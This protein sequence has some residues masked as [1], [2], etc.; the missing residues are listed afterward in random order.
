ME[1]D[2]KYINYNEIN[3]ESFGQSEP[4]TNRLSSI[5]RDYPK[6]TQ[7]F[8]ELIQNA[9]DARAT[10]FK[11][12]FDSRNHKTE[13]L[14][15]PKMSALQGASI[16]T[17]NNAK[18][19]SKDFESIRNL[20]QSR[21]K[22]D[23][24]KIGTFGIG[25]NSVYHLTDFP[26]FVS[27]KFITIFD[28][29]RKCINRELLVHGDPGIRINFVENSNLYEKY[30]DQ[31]SPF[32]IFGCDIKNKKPFNGT[33]FR[34]PL[35][36]Q[37]ISKNSKISTSSYDN[38]VVFKLMEK[39]T[40]E[41][42]ENIL[43]LKHVTHV[44]AYIMTEDDIEPKKI[45]QLDITELTTEDQE[46]R[47]KINQI[48]ETDFIQ[49]LKDENLFYQ[50]C[51]N[52]EENFF[53]KKEKKIG[54][55]ILSCGL[56][57]GSAKKIAQ[58]GKE[59]KITGRFVPWG[60]IA[61]CISEKIKGRVFCFLPLASETGL[62]VHVNSFF[63]MSSNRRDLWKG[64]HS[65]DSDSAI[66]SKWNEAL[67]ED[68]LGPCYAELLSFIKK[69]NKIEE[70]YSLFPDFSSIGSDWRKLVQSCYQHL[71]SQNIQIFE[72]D[73]G[74][75]ISPKE[76]II[77]DNTLT[78]EIKD[79]S[80]KIFKLTNYSFLR[81]ISKHVQN[82]FELSHV[83]L[84]HLDSNVMRTALKSI[85]PKDLEISKQEAFDLL[86]FISMDKKYEDFVGVP[87]ILLC[88]GDKNVF[89]YY[90]TKNNVYLVNSIE[91][92]LLCDKI[93]HQIVDAFPNEKLRLLYDEIE[94]SKMVNLEH[95]NTEILNTIF[96]SIFPQ[97]WKNK[98]ISIE[99]SGFSN[100]FIIKMWNYLG[101]GTTEEEKVANWPLI[102]CSFNGKQTLNIL[103]KEN[104][105][106]LLYI[107]QS[108]S[109]D[110]LDAIYQFNFKFIDSTIISEKNS[111]N[112]K[113][114]K[115][116]IDPVI[117]R[118]KPGL[119]EKLSDQQKI[120]LISF[121]S[122][123][124]NSKNQLFS[125][126]QKS[127]I[128][129]L[130]LFRTYDGSFG[131]LKN[132]FLPPS[133]FEVKYLDGF[134]NI[135]K[136]NKK[137]TMFLEY[138]GVKKLNLNQFYVEILFPKIA[139][140]SLDVEKQNEVMISLITKDLPFLLS[141]D[142]KIKEYLKDLKFI[143]VKNG[144]F[145]SPSNVYDPRIENLSLLLQNETV[146]PVGK[147][148][149]SSVLH[150]LELLGMNTTLS[151]KNFKT[152]IEKS[153]RELSV[154]L[155][156]Y[157]DKNDNILTSNFIAWK[158]VIDSNQKIKW[159][160]IQSQFKNLESNLDFPLDFMSTI[161]S[162]R[163]NSD[164]HL[165]SSVYFISE[166]DIF[167]EPL[168]Q[169]LGWIPIGKNLE[170]FSSHIIS[171][172]KNVSITFLKNP[173]DLDIIN[174]IE[175]SKG[176]IYSTLETLVEKE[177]IT[178]SLKF[179]SL[180]VENRFV[181]PNRVAKYLNFNLKP[182]LFELPAYL[183]K[184]D[185]LMKF[186]SIKDQFEPSDLIK[187]LNL[188]PKD[189]IL[190]KEE[191]IQIS[192]SILQKIYKHEGLKNMKIK[193]P[194]KDGEF[195]NKKLLLYVDSKEKMDIIT[196]IGTSEFKFVHPTIAPEVCESLG[197]VS[198]SQQLGESNS[199]LLMMNEDVLGESFGQKISL[200]TRIGNILQD[201]PYSDNT[202][203]IELLQ[204]AEDAGA[205]Q[206]SV[207]Y[208]KRT[209]G[210][211]RLFNKELSDFQGPSLLIYNNSV[212]SDKDI[213]SIQQ[214]GN[215]GKM[216]NLEK[217]GRF[218]IGF[219]SV[220]HLTDLPSFVSDSNLVIMDP[221]H[222]FVN[223]SSVVNPGRKYKFNSKGMGELFSDQLKPYQFFGFSSDDAFNGTIFRLPLRNLSQSEK[224]EL[225]EEHWSETQ[226]MKLINN[227]VD[228][229]K[230]CMIF[231][232]NVKKLSIHIQTDDEM[233]D[234]LKVNVSKSLE[235]TSIENIILKNM[236][237]LNTT[238]VLSKIKKKNKKRE[239]VISGNI[240]EI[241][242]CGKLY[243]EVVN[244][245]KETKKEEWIISSY[246]GANLNT[247]KLISS[248][249]D[250]KMRF[251]P[252]A[253]VAYCIDEKIR[254]RV[255]SSLPLPIYSGL[256]VH[257]NSFFEMG[258]NRREI[259][260]SKT[261]DDDIRDT[262]NKT[263]IMSNVNPA[264]LALLETLCSRKIDDD[265]KCFQSLIDLFPISKNFGKSIFSVILTPF[266]EQI[267]KFKIFHRSNVKGFHILKDFSFY[268]SSLFKSFDKKM[269]LDLLESK[270]DM[271]ELP[272]D[273]IEEFKSNGLQNYLLDESS[274]KKIYKSIYLNEKNI[275]EENV[276]TLWDLYKNES[277]SELTEFPILTMNKEIKKMNEVVTTITTLKVSKKKTKEVKKKTVIQNTFY[278]IKDYDVIPLI[279][280][281]MKQFIIDEK[282]AE[283]FKNKNEGT[284]NEIGIFY[285]NAK[286]L[287]GL[288]CKTPMNFL[289]LNSYVSVN[290]VS[291]KWIE[292]LW[293]YFGKHNEIKDDFLDWSLIPTTNG[294]KKMEKGKSI[295]HSYLPQNLRSQYVDV[296]KILKRIEIPFLLERFQNIQY[297]RHCVSQISNNYVLNH[298]NRSTCEKLTNDEKSSLI[299][300]FNPVGLLDGEI[301]KLKKLPLFETITGKFEQINHNSCLISH[302]NI[303]PMKLNL[304]ILK[305]KI[306]LYSL[307]KKLNIKI[308]ASDLEIYDQ[309]YLPKFEQLSNSEKIIQLEYIFKKKSL[310]MSLID[311]L[312]ILKFLGPNMNK[313]PK[314]CFNPFE[315]LFIEF[316]SN[317]DFPQS[318][319]N[320][321]E[322][323]EYLIHCG[324][325]KEIDEKFI[326]DCCFNLQK[327][328]SKEEMIRKS[329]ILIE[330]IMK[331]ENRFSGSF[332]EEIKQI[333][334]IP[335]IELDK[336]QYPNAKESN[337]ILE[338]VDSFIH[339]K[340]KNL[341]WTT[342]N[343]YD[344]KKYEKFFNLLSTKSSTS[345]YKPKFI[346]V[347][348][349]LHN[350]TQEKE[351]EIPELQKIIIEIYKYLNSNI[352]HS[353]GLNRFTDPKFIY[354]NGIFHFG[355]T[356]FWKM[357]QNYPPY[358]YA[359]PEEYLEFKS[360]FNFFQ[361]VDS[362]S[363]KFCKSVLKIL[364]KKNEEKKKLSPSK[365]ELGFKLIKIILVDLN[366][367]MNGSFL[368][369]LK[370]NLVPI[371][372]V[373][374]NDAPY[375]NEKIHL[376]EFNILHSKLNEYSENLNLKRLS[377]LVEERL[378]F[379]NQKLFSNDFTDQINKK[380]KS[381]EFILGL[382]R[383]I[384]NEFRNEEK[385]I[386]KILDKIKELADLKMCLVEFLNSSF[387]DIRTEKEIKKKNEEIK[388]SSYCF[389][390]SNLKNFYLLKELP[391][392][393]DPFILISQEINKFLMYPL[394]DSIMISILFKCENDQINIVL[395]TF[396]ISDFIG[397]DKTIHR[398]LGTLILKKD[399]KFFKKLND[400]NVKI[401]ELIVYEQN[402]KKLYYGRIVEKLSNEQ[403]KVKMST[404]TE[405]ILHSDLIFQFVDDCDEEEKVFLNDEKKSSVLEKLQ[406]NL[407]C[408]ITREI[409]VN[410]VIAS[411]GFT[412]E[413]E[414]IE[415]WM[416]R[417]LN[418]PMTRE[419]M[420][421]VLIQN[422]QLKM[423][424]SEII[425][426]EK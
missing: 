85:D 47:K 130:K 261:D 217:I 280:D 5:L 48:L 102:P 256:N 423:I 120:S 192:V 141:N 59:S 294:M 275:K 187:V 84:K 273:I 107:N 26:C 81:N 343:F 371:R 332:F 128:L 68:I 247:W 384:K 255:Y 383:I 311:Q 397:D 290:S 399:E 349:H 136:Y 104:E 291:Q 124:F 418:S 388:N 174:F 46:K 14:L 302:S 403:F 327:I 43:F 69:N 237:K 225:S 289:K 272:Q 122:E 61:C 116:S 103:G 345:F 212:F 279:I 408:P 188:I 150:N 73:A 30:S 168:K 406:S 230:N 364:Y 25:F 347:L 240:D 181:E 305:E 323:V 160:P 309:L 370:L 55:W 20:A 189:S 3:F 377:L 276:F 100:E 308:Y 194:T 96:H 74:K 382:T 326:L 351:T 244:E 338:R 155:L 111:G 300:F 274:V 391:S 208:D 286:S 58:Q 348:N 342:M 149:D 320:T 344:S 359:C 88:N 2:T 117:K 206:F 63:E 395:D 421:S 368:F 51:L 172:L 209:H 254:G 113:I 114:S 224:S 167:S 17:F 179:S 163:P 95:F 133:N 144:K 101:L 135:L 29:H 215:Q 211:K 214:L 146:F 424:I 60:N 288:L 407:V 125:D 339:E 393:L 65:M 313:S 259:W 358:L 360:L 83:L 354:I 23:S 251:F 169:L 12:V 287:E 363:E 222:K 105:R 296:V 369:D 415:N 118:L 66:K 410:P 322:I 27:D 425:D 203:F 301:E 193:L 200:T 53:E 28:P 202:I 221:H 94:S 365:I 93:D 110:I 49:E 195:L 231:L 152:L 201:Y 318:P 283:N 298:L 22:T 121:F 197:I 404:D 64:S 366:A 357:D 386:L 148:S 186:I 131:R 106:N 76:V 37:E 39:F 45:Y 75:S 210:S 284:L 126:D 123:E 307:Y 257:I 262:W 337:F 314:Q 91:Y 134:N 10:E 176:T 374:V 414:A 216:K 281:E 266:Y 140:R 333:R 278:L 165:L 11:I 137:E 98:E 312:S 164:S 269:I 242:G 40:K 50:Y 379:Q 241:G 392:Y 16:M 268:N 21:K 132:K 229:A 32:E 265:D 9:D 412:Y 252:C 243:F 304:S 62:P 80:Q 285:L 143:P 233:I 139:S 99:E 19:E 184:Y 367:S 396:N 319:F 271:I 15:N 335:K 182:F 175:D 235:L 36:T 213:E 329:K 166:V 79:L 239:Q 420:T 145:S 375:L 147:F 334:L 277:L 178:E 38:D 44:S 183:T 263:M 158:N 196:S 162:T 159:I 129:S 78:E 389:I 180:W 108:T 34:F 228:D 157:L 416:K 405:S 376:G 315:G 185:K 220:Y 340:F 295:V 330:T 409:F 270:K 402:D 316:L 419:R 346:D 4:L 119:I 151:P 378:N 127:F 248:S 353:S 372:R 417:S 341:C 41:A 336:I 173:S 413:K 18:F 138:L 33:I 86:S 153:N 303:P 361:V 385:N 24:S 142:P 324:L 52:V 250:E 411:D 325:K 398:K 191:K 246:F 190:K 258:S 381:E 156:K 299:E 109:E 1:E 57:G 207:V 177:L 253:S 387:F 7:I 352:Q 70:L 426:D 226:T 245:K 232:K 249:N 260:Q 115:L 306:S 373:V 6:G 394:K 205:T 199:S 236:K 355:K 310:R 92:K 356:C 331:N 390:D 350:L 204:N 97:E 218:G 35:R 170:S 267:G 223:G 82:G 227:F 362:P 31:F 198:I 238:P 42:V 297:L 171:H 219:N 71:Y 317:D 67:I 154:N 234:L 422:K 161:S 72:D 264:F 77:P 293:N 112:L 13:K 8:K 321:K 400:S 56:N 89:R 87:L 292:E 54:K 90:D 380:L 282:L 328:K 401:N